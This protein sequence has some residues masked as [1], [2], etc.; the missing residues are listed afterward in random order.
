MDETAVSKQLANMV[1]FIQQE[2]KEKAEEI[3][4]KAEEECEA[5][6]TRLIEQQRSKIKKEYERKEKAVL[7]AKKIAES[8]EINRSRIEILK[9]REQGIIGIMD[10]AKLKLIELS[11]DR[12]KYR[13][14]M[15]KLILQG[16]VILGETEVSLQAR[17]EDL[18]LVQAVMNDAKSQYEARTGNRVDLSLNNKRNLPSYPDCSGGVVLSAQHGRI[19]CNNTLDARLKMAYDVSIPRIRYT[20]FNDNAPVTNKKN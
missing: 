18:D 5:E 8:N 12:N 1:S 4:Q 3:S 16:L 7:V 17:Q 6:K 2:A 14:V 19:V 15:T 9:E 13:D 20:L 10:E 11:N